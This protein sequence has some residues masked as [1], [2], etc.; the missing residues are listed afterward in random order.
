MKLFSSSIMLLASVANSMPFDERD[1]SSLAVN[2]EMIGNTLVKATITNNGGSDLKL[3][4][5]GSLIDPD[6]QT[7][8]AEIFQ[9][10]ESIDFEGVYVEIS[11]E[12]V[13]DTD[14]EAL[15]VG[16]TLETTFDVGE[17]HNLGAGG[18]F[19]LISTGSFLYA[20][21]GSN[22][23]AGVIQFT[24]NTINTHVDGAAA[25]SIH[26]GFALRARHILV[27]GCQGAKRAAVSQAIGICRNRARRAAAAA[28]SGPAARMREY[29]KSAA[30]VTRNHVAGIFDRIAV[31]CSSINS[32][33]AHYYCGDPRGVCARRNA[34]AYAVP[35]LGIIGTCPGYY[36]KQLQNNQCHYRDQAFVTLHETGH[37]FGLKD[38]NRAYSYEQ[39]R[40]LS[41]AQNLRHTNSYSYFAKAVVLN[42]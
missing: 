7:E 38:I 24:S 28:R 3:F 37:L 25:S 32:G 20:L 34:V 23:I 9:N 36:Q 40:A 2:L 42:C 15:R 10:G 8:K 1:A 6:I 19:S 35:K 11:M 4:K 26:Q 29:F 5:T 41:A 17:T 21:P 31:A 16:Q 12:D 13:D 27:P 39:T 22:E 30:P 14:F 18:N 33:G